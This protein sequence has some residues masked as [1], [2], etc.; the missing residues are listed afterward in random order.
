MDPFDLDYSGLLARRAR[1]HFAR[2]DRVLT[3]YRTREGGIDLARLALTLLDDRTCDTVGI[4][5]L[6]RAMLVLAAMIE[7]HRQRSKWAPT[8]NEDL[9][10]M[11]RQLMELRVF[12]AGTIGELDD[13]EIAF[14][15]KGDLLDYCDPSCWPQEL[16]SDCAAEDA[17]WAIKNARLRGDPIVQH[18]IRKWEFGWRR[19]LPW[20][21]PHGGGLGIGWLCKAAELGNIVAQ[22]QLADCYASGK[23]ASQN[24]RLAALW[25][26]KAAEQ[27][28]QVAQYRLGGFCHRGRGVSQDRAEAVKWFRASAGAGYAP[29]QGSLGLCCYEGLGVKQD[30]V[31]AVKWFRKAAEQRFAQA[32]YNLGCCYSN[33]DGVSQD[34]SQAVEYYREAAEQGYA[35]AQYTLSTCYFDGLGVSQDYV[36]AY[37]W[38][39]VIPIGKMPGG[40]EALE[41]RRKLQDKLANKMTPE[42]ILEARRRVASFRPTEYWRTVD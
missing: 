8:Q 15:F 7:L 19:F 39:N 2:A 33:G 30:Y 22:A 6:T 28:D 18:Y 37:K 23:G 26:R 41:C 25:Y 36:E 27:G 24:D 3:L 12:R 13:I 4:K 17:R 40:L 5:P 38:L 16:I 14:S 9:D 34:Y 35:E 31:E 20:N 10:R 29:A 11:E 42:D 21:G 1:E 32:Q